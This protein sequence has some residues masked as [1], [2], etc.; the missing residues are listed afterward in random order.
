MFHSKDL[1]T[2]IVLVEAEE[3][4]EVIEMARGIQNIN[5]YIRNVFSV[6]PN[7]VKN[8]P[9]RLVKPCKSRST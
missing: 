6:L 5:S 7:V 8:R 9:R 2:K 1:D 3:T 4:A